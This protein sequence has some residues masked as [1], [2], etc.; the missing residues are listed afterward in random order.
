MF[1]CI[2][3]SFIAEGY[4]FTRETKRLGDNTIVTE[5]SFPSDD[6]IE[7]TIRKAIEY[8]KSIFLEMEI[9]VDSEVFYSPI[10]KSNPSQYSE[11][12]DDDDDPD[13]D[14]D[15][16]EDDNNDDKEDD[17]KGKLYWTSII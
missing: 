11:F 16:K 3:V 12:K 4:K 2:Y 10:L 5:Q 9:H 17:K 6:E 13:D 14:N 8:V 7:K 1:N 15:D